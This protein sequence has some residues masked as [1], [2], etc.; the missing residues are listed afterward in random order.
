MGNQQLLLIVLSVIIIGLA[1]AMG[2][3]MF[4]ADSVR[5]NKDAIINDLQNLATDAVAFR[6]IPSSLSGGG[7]SFAGYAI[8][9]RLQSSLD[10][11][12]MPISPNASAATVTFVGTS[13]AGYGTVT[14]V[15]DSTGKLGNFAFTGQF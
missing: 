4:G 5:A 2:M 15:L 9:R 11:T 10:A 14:A 6:R 13:A 3:V 7:G 8:P 12:Y 1:V